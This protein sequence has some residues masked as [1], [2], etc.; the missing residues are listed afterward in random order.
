MINTYDYGTEFQ[1][2]VLA[3]A[4][5]DP[6]FLL[7]YEDVFVPKYFEGFE[8]EFIATLIKEHF[9]RYHKCPVVGSLI[10]SAHARIRAFNTPDSSRKMIFEIIDSIANQDISTLD[11]I[12]HRAGQFGR[13]QAVKAHAAILIEKLNRGDD[14]Y[15]KEVEQFRKA[16]VI[17][18][19]VGKTRF[20]FK[21]KLLTLPEILASDDK[22]GDSF[23]CP[24][25]FDRFDTAL[26][27]GIA[28]GEIGVYM[29]YF[30]G[31]KSQCLVHTAANAFQ[32]GFGVV[33]YTLE[34]HEEAVAA[35]LGARLTGFET[36]KIKSMGDD[37]RKRVLSKL[38]A[39]PNLTI[40][41]FPPKSVGVSALRADLSILS[42][43]DQGKPNLVI[44]DY[45]DKLRSTNPKGETYADMGE[46]YDALIALAHDF[47]VGI[48]TASQVQRNARSESPDYWI[49][50]ESIADSA[51]KAA[52]SDIIISLNQTTQEYQN[53][54]LRLF[55]AKFRRGPGQLKVYCSTDF[56]RATIMD[57]TNTVD[58]DERVE[59]VQPVG[60]DPVPEGV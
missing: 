51:L 4:L 28:P 6:S 16:T 7:N 32:K 17:G 39:W 59:Q 14:S 44:V 12:A 49:G 10:A 25:G 35:R 57:E 30:G 43:Q 40:K 26:D 37:F 54:R 31:G 1:T 18:T 52:H 3:L 9:D 36:N 2:S 53:N 50:M 58:G 19:G 24:L 13:R 55:G 5:N 34:L 38:D 8:Y 23:K 56:S 15:D 45:A 47:K 46:I 42:S 41:Y 29:G 22:Y 21:E 20:N 11:G 27:G 48:M 60:E 33:Y